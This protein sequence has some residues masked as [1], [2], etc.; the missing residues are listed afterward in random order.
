MKYLVLIATIMGWMFMWQKQDSSRVTSSLIP[1]YLYSEGTYFICT[2]MS[3]RGLLVAC[4]RH[5]GCDRT[6]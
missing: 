1:G 2:N 3:I 4:A 6:P 5:L